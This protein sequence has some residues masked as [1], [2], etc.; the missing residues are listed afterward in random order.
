V[1]L[2]DVGLWLAAVWG[3]HVH[4]PAAAAWFDTRKGDLLMCRVTH[5]SLLRLLSNP[6]VMHGDV[7]TR[8]GAWRVLD[9]LFD[10]ER[11]VW[12]DEPSDLNSVFRA[13][14][15]RDDTSHKLWTDD[16]LAAFAQTS[17]AEFAT[18]D[19]KLAAR[20]PS[21]RVVTIG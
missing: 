21:V 20:Y 18:L 10:D 12:A 14:S 11:V 8:S 1:T 3:R 6:S 7:V 5:S 2:I 17:N 13:L 19:R 4:H 15:A 9:Q 16:Y